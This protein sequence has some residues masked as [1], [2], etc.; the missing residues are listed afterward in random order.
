MLGLGLG[1]GWS[2]S[3]LDWIVAVGTLAQI[4]NEMK[5][6]AFQY[7]RLDRSGWND[8]LIE[9]GQAGVHV[10]VSSIGS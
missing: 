6:M 2:F 10:S 1:V 9:W 8:S 4:D 3:I 5:E 7:P